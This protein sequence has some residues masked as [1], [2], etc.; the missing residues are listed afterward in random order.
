MTPYLGAA[1]SEKADGGGTT[2]VM[3]NVLHVLRTFASVNAYHSSI[4]PPRQTFPTQGHMEAVGWGS[5]L[6][7]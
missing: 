5:A 6:L 3:Y 2:C 4:H 1:G 7:G